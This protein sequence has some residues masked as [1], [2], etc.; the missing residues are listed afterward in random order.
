MHDLKN[1]LAVIELETELIRQDLAA[2]PPSVRAAVR[3][4]RDNVAFM[5]RLVRDLLDRA[6]LDDGQL[7]IR[8][9]PTE[10][11]SLIAETVDRSVPAAERPRVCIEVREAVTVTVDELRIQRVVANLVDNALKHAPRDT[12]VT[13]R[14][15]RTGELA[16]VS[17]IDGGS[18]VDAEH[19]AY[20]FDKYTR[21]STADGSGLGLYISRRIVEAHGGHLGFARDPDASSRFFFALPA[22]EPER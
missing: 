18:G 7:V 10:L 15:E 19:T 9:H 17:V 12:R 6:A 4:I 8:R 14:I 2:C 20:L 3:R 11:S 21:A 1:P 22:A 16:C 5:D 13:V